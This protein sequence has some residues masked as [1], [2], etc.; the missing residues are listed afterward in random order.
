MNNDS[1]SGPGSHKL[2]GENQICNIL[3]KTKEGLGLLVYAEEFDLRKE[4]GEDGKEKCLD[5]VE[6]GQEDVIPFITL[7]RSG[8]LCGYKRGTGLYDDPSGQLLIW[9]RLGPTPE[10]MMTPARLTLVI[11]PYSTHPDTRNNQ[12]QKC[13]K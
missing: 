3:V 2:H 13:Q 8:R 11:T 12:L 7:K 5:Y 6:F 4:E 10:T 9:L 1:F